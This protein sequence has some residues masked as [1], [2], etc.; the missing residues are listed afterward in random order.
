M[1]FTSDISKGFRSHA[2]AIEFIS[3]H[4]LWYYFIFPLV[5]AVLLWT[6]GFFSII[7][8]TNSLVEQGKHQLGIDHLQGDALGWLAASIVKVVEILLDIVLVL[9]FSSYLKY[10]VLIFCSPVLALLSER[11]E[12]IITGKKFPFKM[13]VFVHDAFRGMAVSF[14][15]LALETVI[16]IA[17]MFVAWIP[18]VNWLTIPFLFLTEWYFMGFSMMDYTY[19]RQ[20]LSISEGS[21]FTRRHKGLA[22]SNGF[23][24]SMILLV[25]YA[26]ICIAPVLSVVA[27]TLAV[28]ETKHEEDRAK[29]PAKT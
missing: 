3:R 8:L 6:A 19:E 15:N 27:A 17:C 4:G 7:N 2:R 25:P 26:G 12:E 16:I 10:M 29:A 23:V 5:L 21:K 24:F 28:I 22:I 11:I 18:V 1:A 14:R 20:R 9:V 13:G